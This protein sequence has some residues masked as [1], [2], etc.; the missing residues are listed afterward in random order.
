MRD[1]NKEL[2]G[3]DA[4]GKRLTKDF[5]GAMY[6]SLRSGLCSAKHCS[7]TLGGSVTYLDDGHLT[8]EASEKLAFTVKHKLAYFLKP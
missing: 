3:L 7:V 1:V 4:I 6:L 8:V 2:S 5:Q